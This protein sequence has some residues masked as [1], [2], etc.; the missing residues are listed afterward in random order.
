[1]KK[2]RNWEQTCPNPDCSKYNQNSQES[3]ISIATYMTK[4]GKRRIFK[5]KQ[6]NKLFSET[7]DTVFFDLKTSEE[8]V[9][10]ALKMILVK[11]DLSGISFVLGVK[12]ETVLEWLKK[13]SKK[14]NKINEA[15]MKE[16]PVTEVQ[17]DEMWSFVLRKKSKASGSDIESPQ[18]AED[19]RQWVWVGF[20]PASRLILTTVVGPR[21]YE[22]ALTLIKTIALIVS[23]IPCFFS[24]GFTCYLNALVEVYHRIKNFPPTGKAGRPKKAIKEPHPELAYGQVVKKRKKGRVGKVINRVIW[25]GGKIKELGLKISTSLIERLN[26]TFRQSLSPL[27]RKTLSFS[28][29]RSHLQMQVDFF[30]VYYNFA[31]PHLTLRTP[32]DVPVNFDGCVTKRYF[33]WTP[34]MRAG[35]TDHIWTFKELL[36]FRKGAI[37]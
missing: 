31:R 17:L 30:Q 35:I 21:T 6:C 11:V 5:C 19:G 9:M 15:L 20:A 16:L 10:M 2:P 28:K 12:E 37:T 34:A 8:K 33:P 29:K 18:G 27:G 23:G 26:L 22:T 13:A 1:M 25:G 32:L 14:A 3:I 24:D 4:S 7:R 36:T